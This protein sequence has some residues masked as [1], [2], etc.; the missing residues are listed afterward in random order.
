MNPMLILLSLTAIGADLHAEKNPLYR[1]LRGDGVPIGS[2]T[3]ATLPAPKL[4]DGLDAA[5]QDKAQE[6]LIRGRFPLREFQRN[7][8][9][10]PFV[11]IIGDLRDVEPGLRTRRIDLYFVAYGDLDRFAADSEQTDLSFADRTKVH[12]LTAEEQAQRGLPRDPTGT[13][14]YVH[15]LFGVLDR[16]QL[17]VTTRSLTSR[18]PTSTV[19]AGQADPRFAGDADFGN[20]WQDLNLLPGDGRKLGPAQPYRA[21]VY[22]TRMTRLQAP[23]RAIFIEY[24]C[25]FEQPAGWFN[26]NDLLK[27]KLGLAAQK[28]VRDFREELKKASAK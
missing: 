16:V 19:I 24:H 11:L 10:S 22:Y 23:P 12:V 8:I 28:Q 13:T 7:A 2:K 27:S 4:P 6:E 15:G 1:Q 26:G 17:S 25:D 14:R 21:L 9:A 18:G 5:D 20:F 3:K